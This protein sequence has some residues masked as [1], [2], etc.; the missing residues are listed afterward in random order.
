MNLRDRS[1]STAVEGAEMV[2]G[3]RSEKYAAR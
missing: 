2:C 3:N 1:D